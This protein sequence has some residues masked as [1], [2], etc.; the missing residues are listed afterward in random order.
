MDTLSLASDIFAGLLGGMNGRIQP[1]SNALFGALFTGTLGYACFAFTRQHAE[2]FSNAV[3]SIISAMFLFGIM[4]MVV[5]ISHAIME[6]SVGVGLRAGGSGMNVNAFLTQPDR[7]YYA[8]L[9]HAKDMYE[10][11]DQICGV[12]DWRC[13]GASAVEYP[14]R[15]MAWMTGAVFAFLAVSNFFAWAFFAIC[16]PLT[17]LTGPFAVVKLTRR[18]GVAPMSFAAHSFAYIFVLAFISGF[19][20]LW[21]T[22]IRRSLEP[23]F[24]SFFP[25]LVLNIGVMIMIFSSKKLADTMVG[26]GMDSF[27]RVASSVASIAMS[28]VLASN[29]AVRSFQSVGNSITRVQGS[30]PGPTP[31]SYSG[32]F[33]GSAVSG[34]RQLTHQPPS[35]RGPQ[36]IQVVKQW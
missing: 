12:L 31:Q 17:M 35:S 24:F 4:Q 10:V 2:A 22:A 16:V 33:T 28:S 9:S 5:V 25:V 23:S 18:I 26:A 21:A 7:I 13:G 20:D 3:V 6:L 8:G 27:G 19:A 36:G 34:Q 29:L 14:L 15:G 1:Y 32:P 30:E 11:A